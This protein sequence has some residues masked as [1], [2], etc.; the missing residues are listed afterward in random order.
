VDI[1]SI[2]LQG[3]QQAQ[4]LMDTAT[5]RLWTAAGIASS[6][7]VDTVGLSEAAVALLSAKNQFAA[8]VKVLKLT[9]NMQKSVVNLV[10]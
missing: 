3:L 5:Q 8:D 6:V 10:G 2:A 9:D 4:V 7:D 1:S